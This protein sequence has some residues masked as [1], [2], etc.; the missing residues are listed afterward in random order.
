VGPVAVRN[1]FSA[2]YGRM[3]V[4]RGDIL[5]YDPGQDVLL[6]ADGFWLSNTATL[7]L[8]HLQHRGR[9]GAFPTLV[10]G[11]S[12]ETDLLPVSRAP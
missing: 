4:R 11:F 9:Q 2:S 7:A 10:I 5:F 6:P 12:T 1:T 8:F 3:A